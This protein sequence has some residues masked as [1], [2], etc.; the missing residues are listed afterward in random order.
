MEVALAITSDLDGVLE[1]FL[2]GEGYFEHFTA[3]DTGI[4]EESV[5]IGSGN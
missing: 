2:G 1:L 5:T 3:F 4:P